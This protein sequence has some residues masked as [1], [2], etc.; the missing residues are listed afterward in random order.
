MSMDSEKLFFVHY[1]MVDQYADNGAYSHT[2]LVRRGDGETVIV[3]CFEQGAKNT[4][5]QI[6]AD[7]AR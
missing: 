4:E 6:Q 1:V 7:S 5:Q 2:N 3:D